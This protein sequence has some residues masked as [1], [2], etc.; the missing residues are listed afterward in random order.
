MENQSI[1]CLVTEAVEDANRPYIL[2]TYDAEGVEY[3]DEETE[4]PLLCY[5]HGVFWI[6][7]RDIRCR[8]FLCDKCRDE[9]NRAN[10][11]K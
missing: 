4:V 11:P 3:V 6:L 8:D 2:P 9:Y 7:P 5:E 1:K 10:P